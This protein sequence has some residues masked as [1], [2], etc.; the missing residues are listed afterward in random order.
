M[1]VLIISHLPLVL[2][3]LTRTLE[4]AQ[5]TKVIKASCHHTV[6]AVMLEFPPSLVVVD[7][8]HSEGRTLVA[9]VRMHL[10]Q[11]RVVVLAMREWDEDFLTWAETGISGY[12]GPDTSARE[13][14]SAVRRVGAGE[15]V[16]SSRQT[17]L[18]L[19]RSARGSRFH[20]T[21]SGIHELT[22]R[23]R[24]VAAL[25]ADGMSNKLIAHRLG[26]IPNALSSDRY[27]VWNVLMST[28][29]CP[30]FITQRTWAIAV[31]G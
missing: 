13:I 18:R 28:R 30:V 8:S 23:E 21:R 24:E 11:V 9:A 20:S 4:R 19:N 6:E 14:L 15:A 26:L 27:D 29:G 31:T 16:F 1:V 12:L 22:S 7:A 25:V 3:A 2:Y 5:D 10:P 17:T